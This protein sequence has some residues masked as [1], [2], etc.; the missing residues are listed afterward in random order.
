MATWVDAAVVILLLGIVVLEIRRGAGRAMFDLPA[1]LIAMR[2]AYI[3]VNPQT[4]SIKFAAGSEAI[5]YAIVFS[6]IAFVLIVI[7]HFIYSSTLFSADTFD[8]FLGGVIGIFVGITVCHVFVNVLNMMAG[9]D[10]AVNIV[11]N[12]PI[13]SEFLEFATYHR[14][15]DALY[16]F[17]R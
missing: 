15:L 2:A 6:V 4:G 11:L 17:N 10:D 16:N 5:T 8:S 12:S 1:V 3:L 9:P 13:G 14:L 7:G